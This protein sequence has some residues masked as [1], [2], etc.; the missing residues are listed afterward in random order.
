MS[1]QFDLAKQRDHLHCTVTGT[2]NVEEAIDF[3]PRILVLCRSS[4]LHRVLFDYRNMEGYPSATERMVF[5]ASVLERYDLHLQFSG[6]PIRVAFLGSS[7]VI[8][9]YNPGLDLVAGRVSAAITSNAEA[10]ME[11]LM[12]ADVTEADFFS[13]EQDNEN[14]PPVPPR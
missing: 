9:S 3:F 10:A 2:Y 1:L 5:S 14:H 4:K 8:G 6:E 7:D 13:V 11:W 12:G